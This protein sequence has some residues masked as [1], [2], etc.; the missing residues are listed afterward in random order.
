MTRHYQPKNDREMTDSTLYAIRNVEVQKRDIEAVLK[1]EKGLQRDC[2][3]H[4][5][6]LIRELEL[7]LYGLRTMIKDYKQ[8]RKLYIKLYGKG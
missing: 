3:Q 5:K 4:S 8:D 6:K 2:D 1:F 7:T